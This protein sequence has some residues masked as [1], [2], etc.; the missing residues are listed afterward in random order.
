V[1]F[2]AINEDKLRALDGAALAELHRDGHLMPLFM[3]LASV[4]QFGGLVARR[5]ARIS[6]T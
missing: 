2:L 1:G 6:R 5:N 4:S 3:A